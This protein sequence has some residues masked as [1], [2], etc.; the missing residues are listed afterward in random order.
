MGCWNE[1]CAITRTEIN[2]G[3]EVVMIIMNPSKA[4]HSLWNN[5]FSFFECKDY[6]IKSVVFG[7]YDDY[8]SVVGFKLPDDVYS[9]QRIFVKAEAMELLFNRPAR[10]IV[11]EYNTQYS[12]YIEESQKVFTVTLETNKDIDDVQRLT[13]ELQK[14]RQDTE[15]SKHKLY[16][17]NITK[18]NNNTIMQLFQYFHN[19][20]INPFDIVGQQVD[21]EDTI[22]KQIKV[23]ELAIKMLNK[24]WM[25]KSRH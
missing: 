9:I 16:A 25:K 19:L 7:K 11:E 3:E 24:S 20:R 8:G 22:L 12:E 2:P 23:H 5:P 14:N 18:L 10:T 15:S 6:P 1:T 13:V 17:H 21:D 4:Y